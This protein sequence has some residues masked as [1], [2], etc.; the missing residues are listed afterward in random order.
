MY[1]PYLAPSHLY[2]I[3][4]L[5]I[6]C[7]G[8]IPKACRMFVLCLL[9][10]TC[11]FAGIAAWSVECDAAYYGYPHIAACQAAMSQ[12]PVPDAVNRTFT[13]LEV[14][15]DVAF[16]NPIIRIPEVWESALSIGQFAVFIISV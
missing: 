5:V 8:A 6:Q 2:R 15:V 9:I 10:S 12:M 11:I 3:T 16:G 4:F 1:C 14:D 13:A 7:T